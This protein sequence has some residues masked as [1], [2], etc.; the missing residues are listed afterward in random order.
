MK[1]LDQICIEHGTDKATTHPIVKPAHCYAPV[2]DRH[3][4]EKRNDEL[5][6]LEI[7]V[8]GGESIESWLEYFPNARIFGLDIVQM[9][10]AWNDPAMSPDPRYRFTQGDQTDE[11]MWKCFVANHGSHW[12]IIIDDGGHCSDQIVTTWRMM[13]NHVVVGGYYCIEDL[14]CSYGGG[15]FVPPGWPS[16]MEFIFE[17]MHAI[18]KNEE[19]IALSFTRELAIFKKL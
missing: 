7:G 15:I 16:H 4:D 11:T 5:R 14:A 2:Y 10:N 9:T 12:D 19:H 18:N 8:G 17:R 1:T 6:V 13:W 3:F